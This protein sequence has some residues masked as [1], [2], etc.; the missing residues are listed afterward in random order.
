MGCTSSKEAN[1]EQSEAPPQQQQASANGSAATSSAPAPSSSSSSGSVDARLAQIVPNEDVGRMLR[2]VPLLAKL[3]DAERSKLG[4]AVHA[5]SF[6]KGAK[7]I[8]QGEPGNG[9]YIIQKG[10]VTVQRRDEQGN[11]QELATLK[12]EISSVRPP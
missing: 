9:F 7:I 10:S 3:S 12:D 2:G 11:E 5:K 8:T 1:E 6:G 4:G